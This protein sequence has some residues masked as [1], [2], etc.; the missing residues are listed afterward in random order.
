M[1]WNLTTDMQNI[2]LNGTRTLTPLQDPWHPWATTTMPSSRLKTTHWLKLRTH[3]TY[4]LTPWGSLIL[5]WQWARQTPSMVLYNLPNIWGTDNIRLLSLSFSQTKSI[6]QIF[7]W[8]GSLFALT[9]S[10]WFHDP[11]LEVPFLAFTAQ[12]RSKFEWMIGLRLHYLG[13]LCDRIL[14]FFVSTENYDKS[15][16]IIDL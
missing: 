1:W 4:I 14:K 7:D 10:H 16:S 9:H 12:F 8:M 11:K 2:Y 3:N 6:I 15:N 5:N 13:V